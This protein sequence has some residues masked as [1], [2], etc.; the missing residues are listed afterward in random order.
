MK[1][2][3]IPLTALTLTLGTALAGSLIDDGR[4]AFPAGAAPQIETTPE[5]IALWKANAVS[6]HYI[7]P[8]RPI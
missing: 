7:A 8:K 4:D 6:T 3:I 5:M 1:S 2:F